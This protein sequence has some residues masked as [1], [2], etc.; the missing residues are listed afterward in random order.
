VMSIPTMIVFR[1]FAYYHL[2]FCANSKPQMLE[3]LAA[4]L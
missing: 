3:D 1:Y 2:I 4:Y